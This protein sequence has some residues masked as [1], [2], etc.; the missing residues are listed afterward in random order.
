MSIEYEV[1]NE[2][3]I[4]TE[5]LH[6]RRR[7][8]VRG[9]KTH[10]ERQVI[11]SIL[12]I[13]QRVQALHAARKT[14][15]EIYERAMPASPPLVWPSSGKSAAPSTPLQRTNASR[16]EGVS[17]S[18]NEKQHEAQRRSEK[19]KQ[20]HHASALAAYTCMRSQ[21]DTRHAPRT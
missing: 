4:C 11:L 6:R 8:H 17:A 9:G 15:F 12:R 14:F 10:G 13:W 3:H 16:N 21:P 5:E 2:G 1:C 18:L 19:S 20:S 7:R